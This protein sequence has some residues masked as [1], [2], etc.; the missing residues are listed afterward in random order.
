VNLIVFAESN[1]FCGLF[2]YSLNS[3]YCTTDSRPRVLSKRNEA[4]RCWVLIRLEENELT[5]VTAVMA[6]PGGLHRGE[7][8]RVKGSKDTERISD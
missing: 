6:D 7:E 8:R 1:W 3:I 5:Q 4:L 2:G